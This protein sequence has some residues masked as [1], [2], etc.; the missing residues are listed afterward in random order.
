MKLIHKIVLYIF[1]GWLFA[2]RWKFYTYHHF[3]SGVGIGVASWNRK[4]TKKIDHWSRSRDSES[5][6]KLSID[7]GVVN[8][9]L[10][11]HKFG[12]S[13]G[14][15]TRIKT[16][17]PHPCANVIYCF[18]KLKFVIAKIKLTLAKP[19]S[20]SSKSSFSFVKFSF[21]TAELNLSSTN[22]SFACTNLK[23]GCAK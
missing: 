11:S 5:K 4:E 16:P 9:C 12:V 1:Y 14:I 18:A 17:T 6:K 23:L 15:R 7:F 20:A 8:Q 3:G 10:K 13:F 19:F 22:Y 21:F 2:N